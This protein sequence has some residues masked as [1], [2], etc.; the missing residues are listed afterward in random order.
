VLIGIVTLFLLTDRPEQAKFLTGEE[1][2]WL[3][4]RLAA[5]RMLLFA[6]HSRRKFTP[7]PRAI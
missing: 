2:T 1:R 3:A 4:A 7:R 5:E 6:S